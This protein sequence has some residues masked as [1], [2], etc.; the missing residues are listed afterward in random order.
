MFESSILPIAQKA[1]TDAV[2]IVPEADV[3]YCY[4]AWKIPWP[5][6]VTLEGCYFDGDSVDLDE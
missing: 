5:K 3:H 1:V 2:K 4:E 6:C